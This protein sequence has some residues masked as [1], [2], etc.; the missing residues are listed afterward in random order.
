MTVF[1]S[2]STKDYFFAELLGIKLAEAGISLWRDQGSLI[3]GTDWRQGIENG[4]SNSI[5]VLVALSLQS[6]ESSYV[7]YEWAY[8]IGKGK[9]IIPLKITECQMHPRLES[10]QHLDFRVSNTLPWDLLIERI[11][12]IEVDSYQSLVM[13]E[14]ASQEISTNSEDPLVKS[15]LNYLNQRG[16]QMVSFDRLRR[17]IDSE[18]TDENIEALVKN[19]ASI[20]KRATLEGNRPGLAKIT[21]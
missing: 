9:P 5:A 8:A 14:S 4:I 20:F 6:T 11:K 2:Y 16:Y 13:A 3:A 12:E 21:P 15:I 17:R 1:L 18:L 19:N 10:I 7:T